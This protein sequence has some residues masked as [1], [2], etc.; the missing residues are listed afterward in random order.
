MP[1]KQKRFYFGAPGFVPRDTGPLELNVRSAHLQMYRAFTGAQDVL[2]SLPDGYFNE[3]Y[4]HNYNRD[5][6]S[7][8]S[9][10][11]EYTKVAEL[12]KNFH[13]LVR[14][15]EI[16]DNPVERQVGTELR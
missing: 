16:N 15:L 14:D 5:L 7:I 6:T 13:V 1:K 9:L 12:Q 11:I 3:N 10:E 4:L 8:I 2:D